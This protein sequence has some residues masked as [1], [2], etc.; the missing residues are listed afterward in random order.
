MI[1]SRETF[2]AAYKKVTRFMGWYVV[3]VFLL[4]ALTGLVGL[5]GFNSLPPGFGATAFLFCGSAAIWVL[6]QLKWAAEFPQKGVMR[7]PIH[8]LVLFAFL[9]GGFLSMAARQENWGPVLGVLPLAFYNLLRARR[10]YE[11]RPRNAP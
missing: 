3:C 8:W 11:G 4:M 10:L 7:D 9:A 1:T 6:A 5:L 2:A